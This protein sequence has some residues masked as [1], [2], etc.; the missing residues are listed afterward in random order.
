MLSSVVQFFSAAPGCSSSFLGLKPWFHYLETEAAP[1]CAIVDFTLLPNGGER[2]DI[3]LILLVIVDDLIRIAGLVAVAFIIY[4]AI[5]YVTSQGS[6]DQAQK[7]QSTIINALIGLVLAIVAVG[8]IA[9]IGR[10]V[11]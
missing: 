11:S 2:S 8:T 1:S 7:A 9:F 4:G 5:Q 3:P 6:P 10:T